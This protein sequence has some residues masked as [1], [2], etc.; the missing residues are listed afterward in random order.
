MLQV[1]GGAQLL[2]GLPGGGLVDVHRDDADPVVGKEAADGLPHPGPS[3]R[4]YRY[5]LDILG[6]RTNLTFNLFHL[7][8]I[9]Y[10]IKSLLDMVRIIDRKVI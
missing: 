6:G 5:V 8:S 10:I 1:G 3:P 2:D 4:H 7:D 9:Y